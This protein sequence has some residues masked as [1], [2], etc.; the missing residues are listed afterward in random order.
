MTQTPITA[1]PA[2]RTEADWLARWQ[3]PHGRAGLRCLLRHILVPGELEADQ[4]AERGLDRGT[5]APGRW[6]GRS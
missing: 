2:A 3:T 1:P 6:G 4:D 5:P